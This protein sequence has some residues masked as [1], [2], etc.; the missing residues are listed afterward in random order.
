MVKTCDICGK[1]GKENGIVPVGV[2]THG[3]CDECFKKIRLK[4]KLN[5]KQ[6]ESL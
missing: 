5:P 1:V 6:E 3:I 2:E 4:V